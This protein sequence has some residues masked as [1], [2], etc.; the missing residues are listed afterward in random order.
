[1]AGTQVVIDLANSPSFEDRAV[2][3]F[4]ETSG[5]NL[6]AAEAAA[7]VRHHVALSIVGTDRTP[8]NGYFRAK[9][10]QE[11]L[12]EA[13]GLPYTIIRSTQFLEFLGGIAAAS[14]EGTIVWLSPG[15]FQPIAADDVAAIVAEVALAAPRN[16]IVEIAGPERAPFNDIVARYLQAVGDPREVVRDPEA[17]YYGGRVEEHSLVPLGEARLGRIG[18]DAWL[19]RSQ[20]SA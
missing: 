17:R 16:G 1:M 13:A 10:A 19:R 11:H 9:V 14:T 4:F 5:R 15:L 12:I 18:L 2:L 8:D 3:A 20:A 7:G 6:L